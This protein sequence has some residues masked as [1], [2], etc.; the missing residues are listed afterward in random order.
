MPNC[1]V[2]TAQRSSKKY[3]F[4]AAYMWLCSRILGPVHCHG[5]CSKTIICVWKQ[6]QKAKWIPSITWQRKDKYLP[7]FITCMCY[8][9]TTISPCQHLMKCKQA[10][11]KAMQA[12][13]PWTVW[14]AFW[15]YSFPHMDQFLAPEGKKIHMTDQRCKTLLISISRDCKRPILKHRVI[16]LS[17]NAIF[18][19]CYVSSENDLSNGHCVSNTFNWDQVF[20]LIG[21]LGGMG[22]SR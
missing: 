20:F 6:R 12:K 8:L 4:K 2:Q 5:T 7:S 16:T 15:K 17:F 21:A 10:Y 22:P 11:F 19:K 3:V 14:Q 18:V 1:G 13:T 9:V